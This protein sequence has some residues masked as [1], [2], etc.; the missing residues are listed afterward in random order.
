MNIVSVSRNH[1]ASVA[2]VSDGEL[3]LHTQEERHS[4]LKKD[5]VP[6]WAAT[7]LPILTKCP[8]Y[9]CV[10]AT[11]PP[12]LVQE[13]R[14]TNG[15]FYDVVIGKLFRTL[16]NWET[17]HFHDHHHLTHAANAFYGSGFESAVCIIFDGGG[18][19][20][21]VNHNGKSL[22]SRER[23][24]IFTAEY[25]A[26]FTPVY[27]EIYSLEDTESFNASIDDL[28]IF[29]SKHPESFGFIFAHASEA[30]GLGIDDAG[31]FMG[32]AAYGVDDS[33]VP[34]VYINGAFNPHFCN[35][36][37]INFL[38]SSEF[39]TK[40][41]FAYKVQKEVQDR[42]IEL[43]LK[44]ISMTGARNVCLSGGYAL[45]CT[46]NY[47]FLKHLPSGVRLYVDPVAHDAGISVGAA[48]YLWHD[49][50]ADKTIRPLKSLYL[51][52][53]PELYTPKGVDKQQASYSDVA[54]LIASGNIVAIY[55]GRAEAG[56]RALGNRSILFDPRNPDGK[57]I[58]NTVKGR[59]WFRPFAGTVLKEKAQEWF[60]M[61]GLEE[62]PFMTYAVDV[63]EEQKSH[64]PCIVHVDGSCRVQTVTAEQ[65]QHYYRLIQEFETKTGVPILFNTSFNLAG[66]PMVETIEDA[67]DTLRRSRLEYLYLPEVGTLIKVPN[68]NIG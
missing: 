48:R 52:Y 44:A 62:S 49:K 58:V 66:D 17:F 23:H 50:T 42:A 54:D 51:G 20:F 21:N 55:Q 39:Q 57:A 41:N 38:Q 26:K 12:A 27:R 59:E 33:K 31:K 10:S 61:R 2:A 5:G 25:P 68:E 45:N 56:P 11:T 64:I 7:N 34:S 35:E 13:P 65:N 16:P 60:N 15:T 29:V 22:Y 43:V 28:Q 6:F 18:S 32:M 4:R 37:T 67:L 30:V 36:Q 47:E 3:L 1:D 14:N 19:F 9:L 63:K 8:D 24:S 46:A 53:E 40:A